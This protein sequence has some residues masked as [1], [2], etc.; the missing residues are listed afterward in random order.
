MSA[1]A[2]QAYWRGRRQNEA[3]TTTNLQTSAEDDHQERT[4]EQRVPWMNQSQKLCEEA[5]LRADW[6]TKGASNE[7]VKGCAR[8]WIELG[9]RYVTK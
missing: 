5:M 2:T 6:S 8:V 1:V 9:I 3:Q 7:L 4:I